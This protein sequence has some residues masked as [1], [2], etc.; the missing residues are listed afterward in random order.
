MKLADKLLFLQR[1]LNLSESAFASR[2]KIKIGLLKK[3][4][5]GSFMPSLEDIKPICEE[6]NLNEEDFLNEKSTLL[7]E[8]KDGEHPC[9]TNPIKDRSNVIY[10][11][12]VREDN[13]RY[14]EK[15]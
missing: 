15:D 5:D 10:E 14:E 6:F 13:S 2:Y 3:W 7:K 8:I 4:M 11:D 9:K 12:Y 1:S